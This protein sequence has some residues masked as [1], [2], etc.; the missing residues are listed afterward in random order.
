MGTRSPLQQSLRGRQG[1]SYQQLL[2]SFAPRDTTYVLTNSVS[3][4]EEYE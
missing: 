2:P 3:L 4:C 1:F